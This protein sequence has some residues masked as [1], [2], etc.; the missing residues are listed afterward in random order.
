[1]AADKSTQIETPYSSRGAAYRP[2]SATV[3]IDTTLQL[4]IEAA[5]LRKQ[6]MY[7]LAWRI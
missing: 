5:Y 2:P 1:M 7:L 6:E 4:N 3:A